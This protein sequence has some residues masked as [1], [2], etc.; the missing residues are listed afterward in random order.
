M[1]TLANHSQR[2]AQAKSSPQEK[3]KLVSASLGVSAAASAY[4][5]AATDSGGSVTERKKKVSVGQVLEFCSFDLW[6]V[7][8]ANVF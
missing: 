1:V 8:A 7:R 6:Y 4:A 3:A 5:T 2:T